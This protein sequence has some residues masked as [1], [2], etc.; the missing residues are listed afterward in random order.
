MCD[1]SIYEDCPF[2]FADSRVQGLLK[3]DNSLCR[4]FRVEGLIVFH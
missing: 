3:N 1:N 4:N 2:R